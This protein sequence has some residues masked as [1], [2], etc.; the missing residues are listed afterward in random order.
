MLGEPGGGGL[1]GA[2]LAVQDTERLTSSSW[3]NLLIC[4]HCLASSVIEHHC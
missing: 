2:V 1:N 4:L 3:E